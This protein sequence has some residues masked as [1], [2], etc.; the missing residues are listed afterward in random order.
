MTNYLIGTRYYKDEHNCPPGKLIENRAT[1]E[2]A[3]GELGLRPTDL[4]VNN[5]AKPAGCYWRGN[6]G[7]FNI[8]VRPNQKDTQNVKNGHD[9]VAAVGGGGGIGNGAHKGSVGGGVHHGGGGGTNNGINQGA[10][11]GVCTSTGKN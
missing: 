7:F 2:I 8:A 11:G 6:R 5:G 9:S 3:L 1:C 10:G 4:H